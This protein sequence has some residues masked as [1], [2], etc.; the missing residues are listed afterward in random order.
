MDDWEGLLRRENPGVDLISRTSDRFNERFDRLEFL[1][2]NVCLEFLLGHLLVGHEQ[3]PGEPH[4]V[5][6]FILLAVIREPLLD[7]G[8]R[9]SALRVVTETAAE[10]R[11][12]HTRTLSRGSLGSRHVFDA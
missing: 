5:A 11:Q 1:C 10:I 4:E 6:T 2:S 9:A 12:G 3:L 8:L 7:H